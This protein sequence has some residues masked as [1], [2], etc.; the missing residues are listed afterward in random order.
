MATTT[1]LVHLADPV[2][3][4]PSRRLRP[5]SAPPPPPFARRRRRRRRPP[6]PPPPPLPPPPPPPTT[7]PMPLQVRRRGTNTRDI[8]PTAAAV[9][10]RRGR[11]HTYTTRRA[12]SPR[13]PPTPTQ[14][15]ARYETH[16][17][18]VF[19]N[20]NIIIIIS[21]CY[22][23]RTLRRRTKRSARDANCGYRER[24]RLFVLLI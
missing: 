2:D 17:K 16:T 7:Q 6:Q 10:D 20:N 15:I 5:L 9:A 4:D 8:G 19:Y 23:N 24:R 21:D 11:R 22:I 1:S 18:T 3:R 12:L 14:S 13:P